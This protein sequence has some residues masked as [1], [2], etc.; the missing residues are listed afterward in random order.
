MKKISII[1]VVTAVAFSL[2][3]L[4]DYETVDSYYAD[5]AHATR[6]G[7]IS[8]DSWLP[9]FLPKSATDIRER[10]NVDTNEAWISFIYKEEDDARMSQVCLVEMNDNVIYPRKDRSSAISWWMKPG[11]ENENLEYYRCDKISFLV[12]DKAKRHAYYWSLPQ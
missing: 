2:L 4:F 11:L 3:Y 7:N 9:P 5:Y 12:I 6:N 8:L 10:H 1:V